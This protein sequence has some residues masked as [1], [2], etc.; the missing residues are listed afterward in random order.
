MVDS[1][2]AVRDQGDRKVRVLGVR[3]TTVGAVRD[4]GDR[5]VP[6]L[7]V[8][9]TA[10]AP[11]AVAETPTRPGGGPI[12]SSSSRRPTKPGQRGVNA[13]TARCASRRRAN[14]ADT[15][16]DRSSILAAFAANVGPCR[17]AS[18]SP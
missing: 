1:K 11:E 7:G 13:T 17:R 5:K 3:T 4:Q 9:S 2:G 10:A 18:G 8:R 16:A 15:P 14:G 6:V 12:A